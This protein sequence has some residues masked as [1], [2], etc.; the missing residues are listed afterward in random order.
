MG[1]GGNFYFNG[2]RPTAK[3]DLIH[4]IWSEE[5]WNKEG[6]FLDTI[7]DNILKINQEYSD[8]EN[9]EMTN[10]QTEYR[11]IPD[12]QGGVIRQSRTRQRIKNAAPP[13]NNIVNNIDNYQITGNAGNL[14]GDNT[15]LIT[16]EFYKSVID[17]LEKVINSSLHS[18]SIT[19]SKDYPCEKNSVIMHQ[20]ANLLED[21]VTYF[22]S[23]NGGTDFDH[24]IKWGSWSNWA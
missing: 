2:S 23:L 19:V 5:T 22:C 13:W 1:L 7:K 14:K 10:S 17:M 20:H 8:Y 16:S 21:A 6:G 12:G 24:P 9:Y 11:N 4:Q 15:G 3:D 18:Y